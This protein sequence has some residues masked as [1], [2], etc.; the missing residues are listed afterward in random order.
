MSRGGFSFG[1][2]YGVGGVSTPQP[3]AQTDVLRYVAGQRRTIGPRF[4][5]D[6][7]T[8]QRMNLSGYHGTFKVVDYPGG[9]AYVTASTTGGGGSTQLYFSPASAGVYYVDLFS[10]DLATIGGVDAW[11][12]LQLSAPGAGGKL[13]S[14]RGKLQV[15]QLL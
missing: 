4:V 2:G 15:E 7:S 14:Q 3:A 11:W 9:T 10:A 5:Y 8:G 13:V 1:F 6:P 12:Q